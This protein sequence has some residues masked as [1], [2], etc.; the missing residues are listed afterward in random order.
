MKTLLLFLALSSTCLAVPPKAVITGPVDGIPG[1]IIDLDFSESVADKLRFIVSPARFPDG[2][3]TFRIP[4]LAD[5]S[6][7]KDGDVKGITLASRAGIYTI[8]LIVSNSEGPDRTVFTVEIIQP[9]EKPGK[10]PVV[11]PVTPPV[12]PPPVTP[13]ITPPPPV[14]PP[15]VPPVIPPVVP[16]VVPPVIPPVQ[17][18]AAPA[19]GTWVRDTANSLVTDDTARQA[20]AAALANAYRQFAIAGAALT[21]PVMFAKS[22][23][24]LNSIILTQR[25]KTAEWADFRKSL[26]NKLVSLQLKTVA[27]HVQAWQEIASGLAAVR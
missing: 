22:Q 11:P 10:P 26:A 21:D 8:E 17:P 20:T 23:D 19:L 6:M 24:T 2:R 15:V 7:P 13:P 1:D 27:D 12:T 5:G 14:V 25:Q 18:P 4:R 9:V 16:P 3:P